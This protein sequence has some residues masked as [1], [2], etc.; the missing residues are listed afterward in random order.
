[1]P[2]ESVLLEKWKADEAPSVREADRLL[3]VLP[4][5]APDLTDVPLYAPGRWATSRKPWRVI[6]DRDR[7]SL[8]LAA[9]IEEEKAHGH[10]FLFCP[11]LIGIGAIAWFSSPVDPPAVAIL[12]CLVVFTLVVIV[13][14][15][16]R[17]LCR[18]SR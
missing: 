15:R 12:A 3:L 4:T 9:M 2:Q 11:V 13:A 6:L 14:R 18:S 16:E 7:L 17:A 5:P 1:M 8:R 10:M